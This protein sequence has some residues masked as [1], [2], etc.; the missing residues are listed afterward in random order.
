M[1]VSVSSRYLYAE[2]LIEFVKTVNA[3]CLVLDFAGKLIAKSKSAKSFIPNLRIGRPVKGLTVSL[4][5]METGDIKTATAESGNGYIDV[6]V[7]KG[8]DCY[9][10]LLNCDVNGLLQKLQN[11]SGY[12]IKNMEPAESVLLGNE[13]SLILESINKHIKPRR[14][15]LFDIR[16]I[17][18]RIESRLYQEMPQKFNFAFP[19]DGDFKVNGSDK[20]FITLAVYCGVYL[21][22]LST[23]VDITLSEKEGLVSLSF[24]A[25]T[26]NGVSARADEKSCILRYLTLLAHGNLWDFRSFETADGINLCLTLPIAESRSHCVIKDID[27]EFLEYAVSRVIS[28]YIK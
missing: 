12:D 11:S 2:N 16:E 5:G 23:C 20:D 18:L 27:W 7:I 14:I 4:N 13:H 28:E 1:I 24:F 6:T 8:I 15:G 10:L 9:A 25:K 21:T 26:A 17:L 19:K 22:T 3:G